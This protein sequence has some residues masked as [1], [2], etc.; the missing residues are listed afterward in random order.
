MAQKLKLSLRSL[1]SLAILAGLIYASLNYQDLL[2]EWRLRGY[3]PPP[4]I[5]KLADDTTMNDDTRRLFYIN[6]PDLEGKKAFRQDCG[7]HEHTIVLGC[8]VSSK[9]IF[10]LRVTDKRLE[11]IHEVTAAHEVLHAAYDRLSRQEKAETDAMTQAMLAKIT[12]Q[13]ILETVEQYKNSDSKSVPNELHSI[14]GTE[15]QSLSPKLEQYYSQY[16][17]DRQKIVSYSEQYQDEFESR[18]ARAKQLLEQIDS[19]EQQI[20]GLDQELET[21]RAVLNEQFQE[22]ESDRGGGEA[23]EFNQ[24]VREYNASVRYFNARLN[25][26][27]NLAGDYNRLREEYN[28]LVV[29]EKE[30]IQA[31]DSRATAL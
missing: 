25:E 20:R 19:L 1:L 29:E 8:Y 14:L 15:V 11:G 31:I 27:N 4:E 12:D 24:R 10:I 3:S 22:L 26:R 21:T 23:Q 6:H 30:L 7:G 2:D 13:R 18:E 9:G 5:V 28:S 17:R 16:F